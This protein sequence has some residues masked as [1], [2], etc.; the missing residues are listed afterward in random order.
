MTPVQ[1]LT[2]PGCYKLALQTCLMLGPYDPGSDA[3]GRWMLQTSFADL[4]DAWSLW[5]RFGRSRSLVATNWLCRLA[6]CLVLMTPVQTLTVPGCYKLA[7]Q[8][9]LM[10]GPYD[11]GLDAHGPSMLQTGFAGL[12]DYLSSLDLGISGLVAW[13]ALLLEVDWLWSLWPWLWITDVDCRDWIDDLGALDLGIG[14]TMVTW[15]L[16][17]LYSVDLNDLGPCDLGPG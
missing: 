11:P 14:S 4:L 3:H 5:P 15:W 13:W 8:T 12:V 17:E 6:W 2:V 9:C 10:L 1:T 16:D 7:L